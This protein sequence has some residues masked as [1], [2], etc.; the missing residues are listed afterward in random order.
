MK[1][2]LIILL[3]TLFALSLSLTAQTSAVSG[4]SQ[5]EVHSEREYNLLVQKMQ[6]SFTTQQAEEVIIYNTFGKEIFRGNSRV[7]ENSIK[8]SVPG[9]Y[10]IKIG[11]F[12]KKLIIK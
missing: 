9:I 6:V 5:T 3:C 4:Q 8:I 11:L 2:K 7:G 12:S 1:S 10:L